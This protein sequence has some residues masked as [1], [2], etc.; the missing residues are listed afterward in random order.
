MSSRRS[1]VDYRSCIIAVEY[2]LSIPRRELIFLT[3][4]LSGTRLTKCISCAWLYQGSP[5]SSLRKYQDSPRTAV[6]FVQKTGKSGAKGTTWHTFVQAGFHLPIM[7]TGCSNPSFGCCRLACCML[8]SG[9]SKAASADDGCCMLACCMWVSGISMVACADFGRC[10][11]ACCMWV[12]EISKGGMWRCRVMYAGM[13]H[14]SFWDQQGGM[15]WCQQWM[16]CWRTGGG[17]HVQW[18][19]E[20]HAHA[21]LQRPGRC[22]AR[23]RLRPGCHSPGRCASFPRIAAVWISLRCGFPA[24]R[25]TDHYGHLCFS[26]R[27]TSPRHAA[28]CLKSL[29]Q[30]CCWLCQ[31]IRMPC[32]NHMKSNPCDLQASWV[33]S[34]CGLLRWLMFSVSLLHTPENLCVTLEVQ[35]VAWWKKCSEVKVHGPPHIHFLYNLSLSKGEFTC[36]HRGTLCVGDYRTCVMCL[37]YCCLP[38]QTRRTSS[39]AWTGRAST[40][41]CHWLTWR[42]TPTRSPQQLS[43]WGNPVWPTRTASMALPT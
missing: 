25:F 42:R 37:T 20:S 17:L 15:C 29:A 16:P 19:P 4:P 13:L 21:H 34:F 7:H 6:T 10:M 27:Q 40:R 26:A 11:P 2:N 33:Y 22:Q 24:A 36:S 14:V 8:L 32:W 5:R 18:Q 31:V 1:G 38:L 41:Q 39:L 3:G 30:L 35:V 43:A 23:P 28:E 9:I 12:S